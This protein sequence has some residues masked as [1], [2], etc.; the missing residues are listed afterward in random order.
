MSF[1]LSFW[2]PASASEPTRDADEVIRWCRSADL[3]VVEPVGEAPAQLVLEGEVHPEVADFDAES[4]VTELRG[5]LPSAL[6]GEDAPLVLGLVLRGAGGPAVFG[7]MNLAW[8][9]T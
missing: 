8:S 9:Q 6:E 2:K 1:D 7:D 4:F 3:E 5:A